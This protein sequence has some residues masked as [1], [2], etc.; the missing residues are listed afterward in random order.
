MECGGGGGR[1]RYFLD[2]KQVEIPSIAFYKIFRI[3]TGGVA[4]K[5]SR[6][7]QKVQFRFKSLGTASH[8]PKITAIFRV[9][10]V[11]VNF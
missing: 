1:L 3:Y 5:E 7:H 11:L 2:Q 6:K 9:F 10:D 4:S 8:N